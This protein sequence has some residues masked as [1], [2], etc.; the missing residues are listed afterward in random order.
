MPGKY[1]Q[2]TE[3]FNLPAHFVA[4]TVALTGALLVF[5]VALSGCGEKKQAPAAPPA[6]PPPAAEPAPDPAPEPA[7]APDPAPP[8]AAATEAAAP[9]AEDPGRDDTIALHLGTPG[10]KGFALPVPGKPARVRITPIDG[11]GRPV[12]EL[13]NHGDGTVVMAALRND[14]AFA[15]AMVPTEAGGPAAVFDLTFPLPGPHTLLFGYQRKG[16]KL[17]VDTAAV[18]VSGDWTSKEMPATSLSATEAGI[19]ATLVPPEA[20]FQ[21]CAASPMQVRFSRRGKATP[22]GAVHFAAV[23]LARDTMVLGVRGEGDD[24]A[25]TLQFSG[26]GVWHVFARAL[27]KGKPV[28]WHFITQVAGERPADGCP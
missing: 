5:G 9:P 6:A 14:A 3:S 17:H 12:P 7:Q 4:P 1:A 22:V 2:R 8:P 28:S 13:V 27:V 21:V 26:A 25:S 16:G 20:G 23:P 11:N 19:T 18:R 15:T 10:S 24:A